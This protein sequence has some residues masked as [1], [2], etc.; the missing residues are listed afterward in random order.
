M[1][2]GIMPPSA[3]ELFEYFTTELACDRARLWLLLGLCVIVGL[4]V[5]VQ[6]RVVG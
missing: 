3:L 5:V 2:L 4:A 1:C 6:G